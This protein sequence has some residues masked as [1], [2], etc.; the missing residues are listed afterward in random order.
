MDGAASG[1][2]AGLLF[3]LVLGGYFAQK[4]VRP[5]AVRKWSW[6]RAGEGA[7]LSRTSYVLWGCTFWVIGAGVVSGPNLSDVWVGLFGLCF[8][9][10]FATGVRD[11][12]EG[13]RKGRDSR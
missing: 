6:G 4:G 10:L 7:P 12:R 13:A 5:S 8:V 1:H 9:L 3:F 2:W 11:A